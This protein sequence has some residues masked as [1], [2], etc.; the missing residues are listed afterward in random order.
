[1][2]VII[3]AGPYGF[4]K[5]WQLE[6]YGKTFLLGQDIKFCRVALG[7]EPSKIVKEIGSGEIKT[8]SVNRKLAKLIVNKVGITRANVNKIASWELSVD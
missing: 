7:M 5:T 8:P 2:K 3:T 1:M 6:C 4:G